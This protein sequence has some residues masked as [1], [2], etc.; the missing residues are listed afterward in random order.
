MSEPSSPPRPPVAAN[1]SASAA[2][3]DAAGRAPARKAVV[4]APIDQV[5]VLEDR[6]IVTRT[7]L[8]PPGHGAFRLVIEPVSP[9]LVDKSLRAQAPGVRIFDVRC[10]RSLSPWRQAGAEEFTGGH[11][12]HEAAA[13]TAAVARASRELELARADAGAARDELAAHLSLRRAEWEALAAAAARGETCPEAA[14]EFAVHDDAAKETVE[15]IAEVDELV[16]DRELALSDA[17]RLLALAERR[18]GVETARLEIEGVIAEATSGELAELCLEYQVPAA[19]WRPFHRAQLEDA[20]LT[21]EQGACLWQRSGEDWENVT[22]VL[23]AERPSLGVE[24]P[25]LGDD[26][27]DVRTK[28]AHTAVQAREQ[29]IERVGLGDSGAARPSVM[30]IDDGGLGLTLRPDARCTIRCDGRPHRVA[31]ESFPA[32]AET[33]YVVTPLR[34]ALCHVRTRFANLGASPILAGPVDLIHRSGMI[35][36][37]EI[38]FVSVSERAELGF[39]TAPEIRAHRE[40]HEDQEEASLLGGWST[41]TVRVVIRLSNLGTTAR[42]VTVC[43]RVPVSEVEQVVITVSAPEAYLLER[44]RRRGEPEIP[45]IT[46]RTIDANGLVTWAV[47]LPPRGRAAVTLE[48]RVKS[49]RGVTGL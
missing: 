48:Y 17:N 5:T 40:Q 4:A 8:V 18:A 42:A 27:L 46:A 41:K 7:A 43:D 9:L 3:A 1:A 34:S 16:A 32:E 20:Q 10:V 26:E 44:Q 37:T 49:Q 15:R 12:G 38:D 11:P 47:P 29:E 2:P 24:P 33:T 21:W 19:A 31:L 14:A 36:R 30:G 45:Q 25:P 6:A 35:G 28:P 13:L 39:G 22:L 23:S